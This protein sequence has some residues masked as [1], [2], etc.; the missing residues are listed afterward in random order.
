MAKEA[1]H[2]KLTS[3]YELARPVQQVVFPIPIDDWNRLKL[4]IRRCGR[5]ERSYGPVIW[6]CAGLAASALLSVL[7]VYASVTVPPRWIVIAMTSTFLACTAISIVASVMTRDLVRD[8][9]DSHELVIEEMETIAARFVVPPDDQGGRG[10][11]S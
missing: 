2:V 4:R 3:L 8:L 1:A 9:G 11:T 6:G 7:G 5:H 10:P